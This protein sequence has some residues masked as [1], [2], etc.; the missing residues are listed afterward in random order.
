MLT[1]DS[2][3]RLLRLLG[4]PS[5]LLLAQTIEQRLEE[6]LEE[7]LGNAME[8]AGLSYDAPR[9]A[10]AA[11]ELDDIHSDLYHPLYEQIIQRLPDPDMFAP[12][13]TAQLR[14]Q[15]HPTVDSLGDMIYATM[16]PDAEIAA[17]AAVAH[18][19]EDNRDS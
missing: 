3:P 12:A 8:N 14:E 19:I 6:T 10:E 15:R 7:A 2:A 1:R 5:P 17:V 18:W 16:L 4:N 9:F 13:I 11:E